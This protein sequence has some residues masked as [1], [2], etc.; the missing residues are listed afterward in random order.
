LGEIKQILIDLGII[1]ETINNILS[2][3]FQEESGDDKNSTIQTN[4]SIDHPM[5]GDTILI[6]SGSGEDE[7]SPRISHPLV[8]EKLKEFVTFEEFRQRV[9][10]NKIVLRSLGKLSHPYIRC[11]PSRTSKITFSHPF[12]PLVCN[13]LVGIQKSVQQSAID[14]YNKLPLQD[15]HFSETENIHM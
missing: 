7:N 11:S 10:P 3:V 1:N 9:Y 13:M 12:F 4:N 6:D 15:S 5:L 8:P 2:L 14:F